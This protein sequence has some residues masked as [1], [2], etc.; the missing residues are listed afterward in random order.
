MYATWVNP[1]HTAEEVVISNALVIIEKQIEAKTGFRFNTNSHVQVSLLHELYDGVDP[2]RQIASRYVIETETLQFPIS[3]TYDF[4]RDHKPSLMNSDPRVLANNPSFNDLACHELGHVLMDQVSRRNG[5]GPFFTVD[6]FN[7]CS[8]SH[9]FGINIM[10]EGTATYFQRKMHPTGETLSQFVF[11]PYDID[12]PTMFDYVL[13]VNQGGQWV[14]T[15]ILEKH[16]ERGLIWM[17][18]NPLNVLGPIRTAVTDYRARALHEL[19][20]ERW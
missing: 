14:V 16:G 9:Q 18:K 3:L 19:A 11:S 8:R 20:K 4:N 2:Q 7:L 1:G 10:A 5:L 15:D 12:T 13:M 17:L 6:Y